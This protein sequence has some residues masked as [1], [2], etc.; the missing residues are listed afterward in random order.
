[1]FMG[2]SVPGDRAN[3]DSAGGLPAATGPTPL[4][5]LVPCDNNLGF[6]AVIPV[7]G[8]GHRDHLVEA[9]RHRRFW[10]SNPFAHPAKMEIRVVMPAFLSSRGWAMHLDNPGGGTFTLGSRDTRIIRPRLISG[11][12]FTA[13]EL[14][15]A[16]YTAIEFIVLADGLVVGGLTFVLDPDMKEPAR[17]IVHHERHE[18][19][20]HEE[21]HEEKKHHHEEER[22]D[23]RPRRVR[24]DVDFD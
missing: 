3:N 22:R 6:R 5:R 8:G 19:H 9:F 14:Q 24:V 7:P 13:I 18:E 17:E 20:H 12:D 15:A 2:V 4:W 11:Q 10:A 21:H 1:M 23:D 16:G